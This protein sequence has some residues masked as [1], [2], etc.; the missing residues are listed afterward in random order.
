MPLAYNQTKG[1]KLCSFLKSEQRDCD[2]S[3]PAVLD[4]NVN[5]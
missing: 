4:G 3:T 5:V 1:E 2:V